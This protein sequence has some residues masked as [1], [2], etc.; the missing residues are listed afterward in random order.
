MQP[1]RAGHVTTYDTVIVGSGFGGTILARALNRRGLR[2][3]LIERHSHPR[4]ALGESSTPLAALSLERLAAD[5]ELPDL[6]HLAA[7]G[8]WQRHLGDLGCGLKRGFTFYDH[9]HGD[10][11]EVE[12]SALLVAAS[13]DDALADC[14]WLREDVDHHLVSKAQ[15]EGVAY[16]ERTEVVDLAIDDDGVTLTLVGAAAPRQLSAAILVDATGSGGLVQRH[17][18]LQPGPRPAT[19]SALVYGHFRNVEPLDTVVE[20]NLPYPPQRAA[21]HH[22]IDEGWLYELR[23]DDDRVSAGAVLFE[24]PQG[25]PEET[26]GA[27]LRRYPALAAAYGSAKPVF[28]LAG[29]DTLQRRLARATGPGWVVLPHTFGFIDPLFSTGIA[30]TLRG[31]ERLAAALCAGTSGERDEGLARYDALLQ[32]ELSQIDALVAG[33]YTAMPQFEL[34]AAYCLT[35]FATVSWAE[36]SQRLL[37]PSAPAWEGFLG[38]SDSGL[39]S[40]FSEARAALPASVAAATPGAIERYRQWIL[41]RIGPRDLAGLDLYSPGLAVPI[42][43]DILVERS[44]RIGL[45][46]TEIKARLHLLRGET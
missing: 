20:A 11:R 37:Q 12:R 16:V 39:A 7:H 23:F 26:W 21:V 45:D 44:D 38:T 2:V 17:L 40:L 22:L 43:L 35:Y 34:F 36:I 41:E 4:F 9:R 14:H 15:A 18:N 33:A 32:S 19:R 8:R 29:L 30:W 5:Y 1:L 28:P 42:D 13:P 46:P 24:P 6:R 3:A 31:V 27:L 10:P 25:E